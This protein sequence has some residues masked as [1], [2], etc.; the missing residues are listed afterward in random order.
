MSCFLRHIYIY[1]RRTFHSAMV[2]Y[3]YVGILSTKFVYADGRLSTYL[4]MHPSRLC[5]RSSQIHTH[6]HIY[7]YLNMYIYIYMFVFMFMHVHVRMYMYWSMSMSMVVFE[8]VCVCVRVVLCACGHVRIYA[9]LIVGS[10]IAVAVNTV[11]FFVVI[12][13]CGYLSLL[14]LV[15]LFSLS[16][17]YCVDYCR[18]CH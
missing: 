6:T 16:L 9:K 18:C 15:V 1:N 12:R 4:S 2:I 5:G 3:V 14:L 10:D 8:C 17:S 13:I 11:I 7:I